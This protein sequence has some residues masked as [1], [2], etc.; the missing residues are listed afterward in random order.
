MG[1]Y[2]LGVFVFVATALVCIVF[3]AIECIGRDCLSYV[4]VYR[5]ILVNIS[6]VVLYF[7]LM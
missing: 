3:I 7:M 1:S 4:R 5:D 2:G 6:Y